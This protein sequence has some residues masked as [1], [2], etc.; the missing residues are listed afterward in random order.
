MCGGWGEAETEKGPVDLFPAERTE[1]RTNAARPSNPLG[2]RVPPHNKIP[3]AIGLRDF[4][5]RRM[6][7]E[8][9]RYC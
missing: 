3:Q 1:R 6:G 8:P 7:L 2:S 5:M 9:T 4:V